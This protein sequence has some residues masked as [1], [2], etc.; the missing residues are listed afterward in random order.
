MAKPRVF[1]SST[2]YDLI[3]VREDLERFIS[4][5]GYEPV[6]HEAGNIAYGK[7]SPPE[8][9][10]DREIQTCEM[11][12]CV[13]GGRYGTE[14]REHPGSS[15]TRQELRSALDNEIQ[16]FIFV[17]HA[18][19]S[20]FST[21]SINKEASDIKY[22]FVDDIRVYEFIE[23]VYELPRNNPVTPFQTASD[24]VEF[25]RN[26]WAGL[27]QRFLQDQKR[28]QEIRALE[29]MKSMT[30]TL[31]ELIRF[32]TE[33]RKDKDDAIQ[34]ILLANH[35][36]FHRFQELTNTRYRVFFSDEGELNNWL[37]SCGWLPVSNE[38]YDDGSYREWHN[39]DAHRYIRLTEQIFDKEGKVKV[40][41]EDKWSDDWLQSLTTEVAD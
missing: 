8:G 21:Y 13:I 10:L 29:E 40:Y 2:F 7:D 24:I 41:T 1:V 35:P 15:I 20:E 9:Y 11:L 14:S 17:E 6:L 32:F 36:I 30:A 5:L 33:E 22:K 16:V 39:A 34:Q 37:K 26:Q 4:G 23:S 12:I 25:L 31:E 18:V 27:F 3:Q 19:H 28:I 38:A